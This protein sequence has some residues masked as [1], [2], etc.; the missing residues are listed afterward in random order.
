M[1]TLFK[2]LI[3]WSS[4]FLVS[5]GTAFACSFDYKSLNKNNNSAVNTSQN[6]ESSKKPS[7][8]PQQALLN[9]I[10]SLKQAEIAGA[11][12]ITADNQDINI[13]LDGQLELDT[14]ALENTRF[15]GSTDID[16]NGADIN[17]RINYYDGKIFMDYENS[18]LFLE[19]DSLL[20][21]IETIP[22]Y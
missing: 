17:A 3:I 8:K 1:R 13:D 12:N 11:I 9:S 5:A 2:R 16:I 15:E 19:T 18:K 7:V 4:V 14:S 10:I 22:N 6:N 20:D 21:F